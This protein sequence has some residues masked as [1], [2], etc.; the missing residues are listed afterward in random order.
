MTTCRFWEEVVRTSPWFALSLFLQPEERKSSMFQID[1]RSANLVYKRPK[2]K[3]LLYE[4]YVPITS[5]LFY[6][7]AKAAYK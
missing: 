4:P 2:I 6:C 7:S 5:T 1:Q 3:I